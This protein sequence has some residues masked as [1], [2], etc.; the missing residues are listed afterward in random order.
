[1]ARWHSDTTDLAVIILPTHHKMFYDWIIIGIFYTQWNMYMY[2]S[3]NKTYF[4]H[5][6]INKVR[7]IIDGKVWPHVPVYLVLVIAWVFLYF[8]MQC[9]YTYTGNL[10]IVLAT[11][12]LPLTRRAP[13]TLRQGE[14]GSV[15]FRDITHLIILSDFPEHNLSINCTESN[16]EVKF[17]VA[18]GRKMR[19]KLILITGK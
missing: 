7:C 5:S 16:K 17:Q 8:D 1:M 18:S 19:Q 6:N 4:I 2:Y 9:I 15:S 11:S 10:P 13:I 3:L 14:G 12:L